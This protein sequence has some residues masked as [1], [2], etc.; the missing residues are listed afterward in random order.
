MG[1]DFKALVRE[2]LPQARL[3]AQTGGKGKAAPGAGKATTSSRK[4]K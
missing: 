4:K 3:P 1:T 2:E